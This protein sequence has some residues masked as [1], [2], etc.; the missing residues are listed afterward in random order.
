M[1]KWKQTQKIKLSE[2]KK[3][4]MDSNLE[5]D[6]V[7]DFNGFDILR[8]WRGKHIYQNRTN[9]RLDESTGSLFDHL[10][11]QY[12]ALVYGELAKVGASL[13]CPAMTD[14]FGQT[15]FHQID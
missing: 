8:W 14:W 12:G 4:E 15:D 13:A 6:V 3:N 11:W 7:E 2:V 9:N 1:S 5:H 10:T